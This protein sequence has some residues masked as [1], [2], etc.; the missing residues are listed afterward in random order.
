MTETMISRDYD[1][2]TMARRGLSLNNNHHNNNHNHSGS[3]SIN[4]ITN[5]TKRL[6]HGSDFLR[7]QQPSIQVQD[8]EPVTPHTVVSNTCSEHVA[9]NMHRSYAIEQR[10]P[11]HE[12]IPTKAAQQNL[13]PV[14]SHPS[15]IKVSSPSNAFVLSRASNANKSQ[16]YIQRKHVAFRFKSSSVQSDILS[17]SQHGR[18]TKANQSTHKYYTYACF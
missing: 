4:V 8:R 3:A 10:R 14:G 16:S 12:T 11:Q 6:D 17:D 1:S 2:S 7:Q 15:Q 5:S 18:N 9:T 13:R